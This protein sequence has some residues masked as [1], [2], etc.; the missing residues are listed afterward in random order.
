MAFSQCKI[1]STRLIA[2]ITMRIT[3]RANARRK[4]EG[5]MGD[6]RISRKRKENVLRSDMNAQET[7]A[8]TDKQRKIQVCENNLVRII[9]E[10]MRADKRKWMK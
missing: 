2:L 10:V 6:K 1:Q 9:V 7:M 8:L 4:V 3:A 5:V